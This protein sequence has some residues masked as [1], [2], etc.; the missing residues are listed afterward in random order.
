LRLEQRATEAVTGHTNITLLKTVRA[1]PGALETV[2][3]LIA[4]WIDAQQEL[5]NRLVRDERLLR[6]CFLGGQKHFYVSAIRPGFSDPHDGG[7]TVTLIEFSRNRRV[8]YKPRSCEG[9]QFWFA[10]LSWLDCN[11]PRVACRVP[12][13][14]SRKNYSWM[15]FLRPRSCQSLKEARLFYFRWGAQVALA[16]IL[17]ASDL[18]RENW[19]AVGSQ[20]V[21]VDA[22][23]IGDASNLSRRGNNKCLD[24]QSLRSSRQD[25]CR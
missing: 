2:A 18:H 10:A 24:R 8:I 25:F 9:E 23:L 21:L 19:L 14:I 3:D 22:E 11:G 20:P 13:L 15:E 12:G 17:G 6:E 7:R 5:L 16:E 1:F 4:A